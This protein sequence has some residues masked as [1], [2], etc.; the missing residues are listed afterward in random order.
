MKSSPPARPK[1]TGRREGRLPASG[2]T[3]L[4][5][6]GSGIEATPLLAA[7]SS[8]AVDLTEGHKGAHQAAVHI[9]SAHSARQA[10]AVE[11]RRLLEAPAS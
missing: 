8:N 2:C 4:R 11:Y 3:H 9:G 7:R 1:L 10:S 6:L 5:E